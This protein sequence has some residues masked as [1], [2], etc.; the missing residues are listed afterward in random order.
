[1]QA[2]K[3]RAP[4]I[5]YLARVKWKEFYLG[6]LD[7]WLRGCPLLGAMPSLVPAE[8]PGRSSIG[9]RLRHR[10]CC[11]VVL[12]KAESGARELDRSHWCIPT[13]D[14]CDVAPPDGFP[15]CFLFFYPH[16]NPLVML[17]T[18]SRRSALA[19]RSSLCGRKAFPSSCTKMTMSSSKPVALLLGDK[20]P[21]FEAE[22]T[23]VGREM[24]IDID[25]YHMAIM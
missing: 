21:D 5:C 1:M 2:K 15:R 22:T 8:R 13:P 6:N 18:L 9:S 25:M 3:T 4:T 19:T 23:Q 11:A 20:F 24:Q 16:S 12:R 7:R 14:E 17:A 10:C